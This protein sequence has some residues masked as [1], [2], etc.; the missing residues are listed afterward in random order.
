MQQFRQPVVGQWIESSGEQRG[1]FGDPGVVHMP[2]IVDGQ[3]ATVLGLVPAFDPVGHVHPS[4]VAKIDVGAEDVGG[5]VVNIHHPVSRT[6]GFDRKR[7]HLTV[8]GGTAEVAHEEVIVVPGV[9]TEA[10]VVHQA[11]RTVADVGHRSQHPGR[12]VLVGR[13]P[14][15][16]L[17]PGA[18]DV[19]TVQR[20]VLHAPSGLATFGHMHQSGFVARVGVVVAG[21]QRTVVV[22]CDLLG[23]PQSGV[24]HLEIRTVRLAAEH[25]SGSRV[26]DP[27]P[28][29]VHDVVSAITDGP[30]QPSVRPPGQTVHVVPA[31]R[32]PDAESAQQGLLLVGHSVVVPITQTPEVR[33]VGVVDVPPVHEHAR[34]G[35]I[36]RI[37]VTAGEHRLQIGPTISI[38][39]DQTT[40]PILVRGV[41]VHAVGTAMGPLL[42]HRQSILDRLQGD[43]VEVPV[44][45]RAGVLDPPLLPGGLRDVDPSLLVD[46]EGHRIHQHGIRRPGLNDDPVGHLDTTPGRTIE[47]CSHDQ[48][49]GQVHP[50][51]MVACDP[52]TMQA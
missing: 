35:A 32:D 15:P 44:W 34:S 23:V 39:V 41:V 18:A 14:D 42:V 37:V 40:N 12:S 27:H 22:E 36:E 4:V 1:H 2:W 30:V 6:V 38:R 9:E 48:Q 50:S 5:E 52:D 10:R 26:A 31:Q 19:D 3:D 7:L 49:G 13:L 45:L 17:H 46:A 33:N 47:Q 24:E 43:V 8:L 29:T 16:L 25:R 11:R 28:L 20:L 51:E 21:E